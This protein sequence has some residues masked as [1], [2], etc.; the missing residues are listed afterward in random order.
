MWLDLHPLCAECARQGRVRAAEE[1][2][3]VIA[4]ADG[5]SDT[6]DN[7]QGL[8]LPCH[9]AKSTREREQRRGRAP[10]AGGT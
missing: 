9:V 1:I 8:C 3:H 10:T 4:L 6:D 7:V 2:D 5:G